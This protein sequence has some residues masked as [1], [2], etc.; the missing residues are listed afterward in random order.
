MAGS[1]IT[2]RGNIN[3]SRLE[4]I[5]QAAV[6]D[7]IDAGLEVMKYLANGLTPYRTGALR[8]A[9][10]TARETRTMGR[11]YNTADYAVYVHEDLEAEHVV[12][13][14]KFFEKVIKGSMYRKDILKEM[15]RA[16]E[17]HYR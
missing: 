9:T 6:D 8:A 5:T 11:L 2:I 1:E 17:Y 12:G 4:L 7:A 10:G 3:I 16:I 13:G 14:A 15:G